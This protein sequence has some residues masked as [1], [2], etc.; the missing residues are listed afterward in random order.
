MCSSS[1][2]YSS[3]MGEKPKPSAEKKGSKLTLFEDLLDSEDEV[4]GDS[5]PSDGESVISGPENEQQQFRAST[6][7]LIRICEGEMVHE[8]IKKKLESGSSSSGFEARVEAIHRS[9]YSGIISR[10]QLQSFFIYS[11]AIEMKCGGNGNVKYAW[12]GAPKCEINEILSHGF[13]FSTTNRTFGQG[14]HLSPVEHP[15]ESVQFAD[16]DED[17]V[18]HMLLC[19]VIMG[20]MEEIR[21]NSEQYNP[22]CEEFDSGV[23]NLSSPRKYIVWSSRMNTYILPEFMV[24]FRASSVHK[25]GNRRRNSL[26][27]RRPNSDW[28]PFPTLIIGLSKFLPSDAIETIT[29]H[30]NDYREQKV[31]RYE[32]IQ[33]VRHIAGDKLLMAVIKSHKGRI[34]SFESIV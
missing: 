3:S 4:P 34:K 33:R 1:K 28:L 27:I 30:H 17:G 14:V 20:K 15:A 8:I 6:N 16:P 5:C 21:P 9:D 22:S 23:D 2:L 19:R 25:A 12:Y 13:G 18:K 24:S 7:N 29:K 26:P 32:M 11:K 10:A 31:T